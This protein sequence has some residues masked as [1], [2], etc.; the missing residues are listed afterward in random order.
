M[1]RPLPSS[2]DSEEDFYDEDKFSKITRRI[3]EEPLIP[4]GVAV[5]CYALF[6][7]QRS[8]RAGNK[9]LTN[10]MFRARI[11]AQGFTLLAMVGGSIYYKKD[12]EERNA[13][14]MVI[15]QKKH[16][17]KQQAWIQELEARDE[18]DRLLREKARR[19]A[20]RKRDAAL[21]KAAAEANGKS[22]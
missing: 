16:K 6:K 8:I 4:I 5:T 18:E 14:D 1:S 3:K 17:E 22:E 12:R 2:F 21:A 19:F 10:K 7:A 20:E 15:A 11:Y 13:K 9:E